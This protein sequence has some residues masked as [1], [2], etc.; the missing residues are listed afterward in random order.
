M[1]TL[2]IPFSKK[3]FIIK[4]IKE[5]IR[6]NIL[7]SSLENT[8]LVAYP[9]FADLCSVVMQ[10]IGFSEKDRDDGLYQIYESLIEKS[11]GTNINEFPEIA[12]KLSEEIYIELL[13][14]KKYRE[15]I[16]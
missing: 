6:N 1:E 2:E 15:K 9:F 3:D 7:V 12:A 5:D 14:E 13:A 10:L 16:K 4:L 8:G 11:N